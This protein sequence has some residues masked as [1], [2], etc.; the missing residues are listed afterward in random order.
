[1]EFVFMST[2][3]SATSCHSNSVDLVHRDSQVSGVTGEESTS[4]VH[5]SKIRKIKMAV[6]NS[7]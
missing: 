3:Q 1:M 5:Y 2:T 6:T 7:S 4:K